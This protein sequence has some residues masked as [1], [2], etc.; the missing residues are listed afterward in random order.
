[1]DDKKWA[2][3]Y[4]DFENMVLDLQVFQA[5]NW[6]EAV[7]LHEENPWTHDVPVDEIPDDKKE[8]QEMCLY[9]GQMFDVKEVENVGLGPKQMAVVYSDCKERRMDLQIFQA[10][11]WKEVVRLHHQSVIGDLLPFDEMSYTMEEAQSLSARDGVLFR[12]EE[13]EQTV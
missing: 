4:A 11:D 8:A 3:A 6:K 5:E 2:V 7:R 13:I 10:E 12:V 9:L 1:M